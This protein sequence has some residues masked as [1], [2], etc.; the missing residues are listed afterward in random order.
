MLIGGQNGRLYVFATQKMDKVYRVPNI[1]RLTDEDTDAF[2]AKHAGL[3]VLPNLTFGEL[4]KHRI[5]GKLVTLEEADY[6]A[7]TQY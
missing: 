6:K 3:V 5:V 1:P 7:R 4:W 2:A